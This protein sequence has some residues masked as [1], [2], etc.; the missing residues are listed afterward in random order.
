MKIVVLHGEIPDEASVDELD[1]L[2][3][4]DIISETL[5]DLGHE[6]V[7]VPVSMNLAQ[8][9][10][11]LVAVGP[12][13]IFN[14]VEALNG[15]GN[16]IHVV[17]S[18]LDT[19]G[20]P[21]TGATA[22]AIFMTSNKIVAKKI[23]KGAGIPTIPWWSHGDSADSGFSGGRYIVKSVW[24][25]ASIGIDESSLV[26]VSSPEQ[27]HKA[28]DDFRLK[29]GGPCLA[30]PF[31]EGREF[32]VAV[33]AGDRGHQILPPAEV[34]F[35]NYPEGKPKLLT[36][37]AKWDEESF[38][39]QNILACFDF[40][41]EDGPLLARLNDL[42][43]RCWEA[44][45]LKGY[46]RID[47]RVDKN[48]TPLVMEINTNPCLSPDGGFAWCVEEAGIFFKDAVSRIIDDSLR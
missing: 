37:R 28:L 38:E 47:F 14:L 1:T 9:A 8:M 19:I 3:Q 23:L 30:E 45:D 29:L 36:Y 41:E 11:T 35:N 22:E 26:E 18:V 6:P 7:P 40:T 13:A 32:N 15:R 20:I 27:L 24:E 42:T 21:Y 2:D 17:P 39:F 25:H 33:L 5:K 12:D 10:E 34:R 31:I 43:H 46:A 48:G 16:L 4:V 44:F